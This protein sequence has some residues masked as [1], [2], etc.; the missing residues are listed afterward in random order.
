MKAQRGGVRLNAGP[1]TPVPELAPKGR[2]LRRAWKIGA[3][4]A[5]AVAM[6]AAGAVG[7]FRGT[8]GS[9]GGT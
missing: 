4:V 3:I 1:S 6:F 7:L 8:H 2:G 9:K 5:L